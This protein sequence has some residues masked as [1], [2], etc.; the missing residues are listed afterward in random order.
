[1]VKKNTKKIFQII[2]HLT[3]IYKISSYLS[4]SSKR[5]KLLQSKAFAVSL[6]KYNEITL[7]LVGVGEEIIH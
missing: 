5:N 2:K 7:I 6:K 4:I 3:N 1:M